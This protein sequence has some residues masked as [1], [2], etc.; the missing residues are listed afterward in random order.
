[1][2]TYLRTISTRARAPTLTLILTHHTH[3][4]APSPH[5]R[6]AL[7][8]FSKHAIPHMLS[9]GGGSIVNIASVQGLASQAGIPAYAA[10]KGARL[11]FT[12]QLANEYV[13]VY[14]VGQH[15][16]VCGVH[17]GGGYRGSNPPSPPSHTHLISTYTRT[18]THRPH[19]PTPSQVCDT[20][21]PRELRKPRHTRDG[22]SSEKCRRE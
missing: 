17:F 3:N 19:R 18:R 21:Y 7:V 11:S 10:T 16:R 20:R 9:A 2:L 12:R 4:S 5:T 1:M 14:A 13:C 8:R 6:T 22:S 15:E